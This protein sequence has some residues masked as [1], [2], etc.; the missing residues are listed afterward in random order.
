MADQDDE[1]QHLLDLQA[2]KRRRLRALDKQIET[3]GEAGAPT[4]LVVERD[5]LR[6]ALGVV[7]T[8]IR[9][10]L[11]ASIGDELGERWRFVA[12]LEEV[13]GVRQSVALLGARLEAFVEASTMWRNRITWIIVVLIIIVSVIALVGAFWLGRLADSRS[14]IRDLVAL[15]WR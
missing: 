8:V 6:Q 4:H 2:I 9:S 7:E 3:Y 14:L 12:Y 15:V 11:H 1:A 13:R 10:P 5:E